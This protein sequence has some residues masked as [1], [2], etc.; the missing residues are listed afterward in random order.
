M[1]LPQCPVYGVSSPDVVHQHPGI[2][3]APPGG[4]L[5]AGQNLNQLLGR[6]RRIARRYHHHLNVLPV[7]AGCFHAGRCFRFVVLDGDHG[8]GRLQGVKH[9]ANAVHDVLGTLAH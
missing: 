4:R 8:V 7:L 9:Q 5:Q 1:R 6:T 2:G 3:T